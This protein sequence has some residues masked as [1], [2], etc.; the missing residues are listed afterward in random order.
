MKKFVFTALLLVLSS[1]AFGA[2]QG[3][4][5]GI[6]KPAMIAIDGNELFVVEGCTFSVFSLD[7]LV[8]IRQFGK[9]GEGPGELINFPFYPNKITLLKDKAFITG[10]GKAVAFSRDGKYI[11]EFKT[12][13][14]VLQLLPIGENFVAKEL[15][16]ARSTDK[17]NFYVINLYD[18]KMTKLKELYRQKWVKQGDNT[19][20]KMDMGFDFIGVAV[21]ADKIFV[22]AS[23]LGFLIEVFDS[24][25]N[26]L[27]D[28]KREAEKLSFTS[29]DRDRVERM[30]E[31]DPYLKIDLKSVG[32]WKGWKKMIRLEWPDYFAPI[33]GIEVSGDKLYV[34]TPRVKEDKEE[35]LV[36]DLKGKLLK[37]VYLPRNLEVSIIA[38][39]SGGKLFTV[40]NDKLYYI[41]E[42]EDDEVWE[43]FVEV[44]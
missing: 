31:E 29:S 32:G 16:M 6:M 22:E 20:T 2:S 8:K 12:H 35:Y 15:Q 40:N 28:I 21:T 34:R 11:D 23:P 26:K 9:E 37:K 10:L 25:G 33:K 18:K 30:M 19:S 3:T 43:L 42:N 13:Q 27:Y 38:Q 14:N 41:L 7:K 4:L 5:E 44:L 39:L 24:N 1:L 17:T 36:M